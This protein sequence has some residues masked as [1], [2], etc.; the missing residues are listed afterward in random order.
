MGKEL[1]ESSLLAPSSRGRVF[2]QFLTHKFTLLSINLWVSG[3]ILPLVQFLFNKT[4]ESLSGLP[5]ISSFWSSFLVCSGPEQFGDSV[6]GK[7]N[8]TKV[9][10]PYFHYWPSPY[11]VALQKK[12][13]ISRASPWPR[14]GTLASIQSSAFSW[15]VAHANKIFG[16]GLNVIIF[17]LWL[18][19]YL[20][21]QKNR[22]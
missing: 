18:K 2:T 14:R 7:N 3:S 6:G 19:T 9:M 16:S 4:I 10:V 21:I 11:P 12:C 15:P 8:Q 5:C 17:Y 1:R 22:P 13:L 20:A